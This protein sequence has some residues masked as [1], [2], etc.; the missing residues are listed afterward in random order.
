MQT[1]LNKRIASEMVKPSRIFLKKN[2]PV[3]TENS[4][5][6]FDGVKI[7]KVTRE[8]YTTRIQS[9]VIPV[10][11]ATETL[12][13]TMKELDKIDWFDSE[14]GEMS[15]NALNGVMNKFTEVVIQTAKV[16]HQNILVGFLVCLNT[17]EK[18][19]KIEK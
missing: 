7:F 14:I 19:R 18:K 11:G 2:V 17:I 9:K 13:V 6:V 5:V 3:V 15:T 8:N 16:L 1:V 10:K 12:M 4:I